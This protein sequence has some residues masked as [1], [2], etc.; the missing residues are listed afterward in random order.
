MS[1]QTG[2]SVMIVCHCHAVSAHV[3]EA[4]A[5]AGASTVAE[6]GEACLAGRDCGSCHSVVKCLVDRILE[7]RVALPL[8]A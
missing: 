5:L 1:Q 6:V 3:I 2:L 4:S 8:P 7:S